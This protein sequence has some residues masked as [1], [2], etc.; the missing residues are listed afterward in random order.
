ME[1]FSC[2]YRTGYA[3]LQCCMS[4]RHQCEPTLKIIGIGAY[5]HCV[6]TVVCPQQQACFT[7]DILTC[8][9]RLQTMTSFC[10]RV[11]LTMTLHVCFFLLWQTTCEMCSVN[12]HDLSSYCCFPSWT[13]GCAS[14]FM[15]LDA[16][17]TPYVPNL[18][19]VRNLCF[20]SLSD[21]SFIVFQL[22][23]SCWVHVDS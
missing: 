20:I 1:V 5:L 14:W 11:P 2:V 22:L 13:F 7:V 23:I 3:Y 21:F 15:G 17:H 4:Y 19:P 12:H 6:L 18:N 16:N 9:R 8:C 10:P